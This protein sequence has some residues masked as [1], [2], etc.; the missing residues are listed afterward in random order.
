M[1]FQEEKID[2]L[3]KSSKR[4]GTHVNE[5]LKSEVKLY[6]G[7]RDSKGKGDIPLV[8]AQEALRNTVFFRYFEKK[9]KA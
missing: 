2:L 9:K 5:K 6:K 1:D 4:K 3:K 8:A 7:R